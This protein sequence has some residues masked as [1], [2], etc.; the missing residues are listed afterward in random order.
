MMMMMN[1]NDESTLTSAS[2]NTPVPADN[3]DTENI[4][5]LLKFTPI[6]CGFEGDNMMSDSFA[7]DYHTELTGSISDSN[8]SVVDDASGCLVVPD[9]V[10]CHDDNSV[11]DKSFEG[12]SS[13]PKACRRR[14]PS[15]TSCSPTEDDDD[16]SDVSSEQ[17]Q[18]NKSQPGEEQAL[19]EE[20]KENSNASAGTSSEQQQNAEFVSLRITYLIVTLVIMLADGLQ[21]TH[22]YV[23]YEGYGF[24]VASL[25]C[26]GF[27]TGAFAS[28]ITGPLVD[29]L[30]R[31]R[32]AILYCVLEIGI[33]MLEQYQWLPG[34]VVS[35]M[36]G[37]ITTNLLSTVFD[38]WLDTEYR[39][40][41]LAKEGYEIIMRDSV[42]VSNLAAIG[43]GYLAHMLA[44]R[45]G[46]V[47]P[48]E[49]AVT[50]TTVAL[51]VVMFVWTE[52]YGCGEHQQMK[53]MGEYLEDA[54]KAF[55]KDKRILRVG[56]IQGLTCASIQIFIFLWSPALRHF[57]K[58]AP[59]G[60]LGIDAAGEPA[61]GLIFG[62]FMAAGVV[63]GLAAP[64][65][66]R[67]ATRLLSPL[68]GGGGASTVTVEV[69][70]DGEETVRPMAVEL[71]SATCYILSALLLLAPC[72]L[73][74]EG[75]RSF[76][77]CLGA[78]LVYEFMVGLYLP[79]EGV[80][81]SI[82]FPAEG[83]A[84]IMTLPR[85]IVN[86]SVSL[87]VVLTTFVT[88]RSAFFSVVFLMFVSA[89][90]Q[91]SLVSTKQ[92]RTLQR[93]MSWS[94][95]ALQAPSQ[96]H[97]KMSDQ[98]QRAQKYMQ[99]DSSSLSSFSSGTGDV[100]PADAKVKCQ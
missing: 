5:K 64:S 67:L 48:F 43:S 92:I 19:D 45:Y 99:T 88:M 50:F 15:S 7:Q 35:R 76:S 28:P 12:V 100:E 13:P 60:T 95:S 85:I 63:G 94:P 32:S 1:P 41:G 59:E 25:Y 78:F 82:Y 24:S 77:I 10:T 31:K 3:D 34:L 65:V 14:R 49:G 30:G 73:P 81:R 39:R 58:S 87:G 93:R 90:L 22:L 80:I 23:L 68:E 17:Q 66:R 54:V 21:G 6:I 36:I 98:K 83:R 47:G 91:L 26:L 2:G 57:A 44:E 38:A 18:Q 74:G 52:N 16:G 71:L 56:I 55:K 89:G 96:A 40:R 37:G 51:V 72:L 84:S 75:T 79:C 29:K 53:G 20:S 42:I 9:E 33:N 4:S 11:S 61:Y 46:P 8:T 27:V 69:E 62:A 97:A 70:G 86:C